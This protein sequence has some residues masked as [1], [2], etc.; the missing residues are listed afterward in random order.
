MRKR[1]VSAALLLTLVVSLAGMS[2]GADLTIDTRGATPF[3][4]GNRSYIPLQSVASFLGAELQWNAAQRQAVV[5]YEGRELAV[6][7]GNANALFEGRPVVLSAAPV[8]ANGRVFLPA[9]ALQRFY[10]VPVAW[11]QAKS[12]L[13][14]Q[15]PRGWGG[16]APRYLQH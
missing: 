5:T 13:R 2:A 7:P 15:G 16:G 12:Q 6:T 4:Y 10:G 11:D 8:V 14:I 9:E 1:I 3:L